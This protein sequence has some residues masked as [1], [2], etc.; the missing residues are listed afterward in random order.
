MR[1][2]RHAIFVFGTAS[3]VA[4]PATAQEPAWFEQQV[5]EQVRA[6]LRE[7]AAELQ[8]AG[9]QVRQRLREEAARE[10][11][12]AAQERRARGEQRR[13]PEYTEPFSR[14]VRLGRTGSFDLSNISG[15][16]TITGGG[17]DEVKIDARKRVRQGNEADARALLQAMTIQVSE[18]AGLVEVRTE[19]PRRRDWSGGVDYT[20]A[21]PS[22][23]NVAVRTVNG[24][25]R[26]T[27]VRGELRAETVNGDVTANGLGRVRSLKTVSGDVQIA[28]AQGDDIALQTVSGDVTARA[29]KGRSIELEAVS[30]DLRFTDVELERVNLRTVSGDI[31]YSGRLVRSGR[32]DLQSHSGDIRLTPLGNTGFDLDA[33]TFSGDIRSEFQLGGTQVTDVAARP[34]RN[35]TMRGTFGDASAIVIAH[36]FNGDILVARR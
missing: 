35:R 8:Q 18:R 33:N 34:G 1:A 28:D 19:L 13:G 2:V 30:G 24:D 14:T 27:N 15:D 32:Y 31:E 10:R 11:E 6:A 22:G 5:G 25:L 16:V 23:A 7:H 20:I 12:R 26:I 4:A 21:L 29:I 3:A 36:T 9:D 17:G